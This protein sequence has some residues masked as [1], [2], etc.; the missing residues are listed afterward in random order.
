MKS[1]NQTHTR[2]VNKIPDIIASYFNAKLDL[3]KTTDNTSD[4]IREG[5]KVMSELI[6]QHK[7]FK[8]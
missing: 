2:I 4:W 7:Q 8:E 6:Q 3:D 5:N 1:I